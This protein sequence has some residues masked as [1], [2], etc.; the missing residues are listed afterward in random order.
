MS[1]PEDTLLT[2][3][4]DTSDDEEVEEFFLELFEAAGP[5]GEVVLHHLECKTKDGYN[6]CTCIPI[7]LKRGAKA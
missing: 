2:T 1:D 5:E 6:D 3:E 4:I 7:T